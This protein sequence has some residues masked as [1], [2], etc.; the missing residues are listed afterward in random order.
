LGQIM[1]RFLPTGNLSVLPLLRNKTLNVMSYFV[2]IQF[3][4]AILPDKQA[5]KNRQIV[6][7]P[8]YCI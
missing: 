6:W 5:Q 3:C 2:P 8:C 1:L 7:R 4:L